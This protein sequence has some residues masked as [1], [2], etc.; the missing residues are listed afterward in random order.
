MSDFTEKQLKILRRA[1]D[2]ADGAL[3]HEFGWLAVEPLKSDIDDL[4]QIEREWKRQR[5][6]SLAIEKRA[7][8]K[9]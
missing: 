5:R 2:V 6:K 9:R 4:L 7:G 3:T 1:L 8:A